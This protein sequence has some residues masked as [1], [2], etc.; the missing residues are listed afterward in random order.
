MSNIR[1][2]SK[3]AVEF[4]LYSC[5]GITLNDTVE[6]MLQ[7]IVARA[8]RDAA[9]HV[10]SIEEDVREQND[11]EPKNVKEA[12]AYVPA[13]RILI[14]TDCPYLSPEPLRGKLCHSGLITFTAQK[15]AE[16]KNTSTENILNLT[17]QN[18]KC[19]FNL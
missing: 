10:L 11:S 2:K 17:L 18:A 8:Y 1:L 5:C 3:N 4:M 19:L 6:L 12:A 14:E 7:K 13:D 9:S 15:V 16:I